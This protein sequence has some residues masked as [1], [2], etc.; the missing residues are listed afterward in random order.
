MRVA[1]LIEIGLVTTAWVAV[2]GCHC[3]RS[4]ASTAPSPQPSSSASATAIP[5]NVDRLDPN[6]VAE[7]DDSAFDLKIPRGMRIVYH[8]PERV[9]ALGRVPAERIANYVR[10]R[11]EVGG[12]ELGAAATVF[13]RARV[14]GEPTGRL[15][16]IEVVTQ[17]DETRLI[18]RDLTLP[19]IDPTLSSEERWKKFGLDS[20]GKLIDPEH[21]Q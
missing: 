10:K 7:G 5:A 9:D 12:V 18:V 20:K 14:R 11:V 8:G 4:Q 17:L 1:A 2:A 16:R 13:D 19:P 6:E 21:L 15:V 3:S